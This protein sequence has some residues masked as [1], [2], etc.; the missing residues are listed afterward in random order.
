MAIGGVINPFHLRFPLLIERISSKQS[1]AKMIADAIS[2]KPTTNS[3][4]RHL[5]EV[6]PF[7]VQT[8]SRNFGSHFV[9]SS[10]D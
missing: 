4:S 5:E 9:T 2:S 8:G 3:L 6:A 7:L 1:P 10:P